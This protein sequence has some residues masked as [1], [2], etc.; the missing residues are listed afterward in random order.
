[1][2][3]GVVPAGIALFFGLLALNGCNVVV[4]ISGSDLRATQAAVARPL[5]AQEAQQTAQAG[6]AAAVAATLTAHPTPDVTA[7]VQSAVKATLVAMG[8]PT[9]PV[10]LPLT[11]TVILVSSH[12]RYVTAMADGT[13]R[14]TQEL[15]DCGRFTL[16]RLD[17]GMVAFKTCQERWV[18]APLTAVTDLDW[19]VTQSPQL[20]DCGQFALHDLGRAR[21]AFES[22][23]GRWL[24]AVGDNGEPGLVGYMIAQTYEMNTWEMFTMWLQP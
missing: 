11:S 23:S 3:L 1:M 14:Q 18:T 17:D 16:R 7:T 21:V 13:L 22:C 8:A 4:G 19:K 10:T 24:T 20:G 12:G 5:V 9:V 15:T 6:V 2:K